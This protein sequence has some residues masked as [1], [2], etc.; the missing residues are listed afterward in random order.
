M[1]GEGQWRLR[2]LIQSIRHV[3]WKWRS[4]LQRA[5]RFYFLIHSSNKTEKPPS[6]YCLFDRETHHHDCAFDLW[7]VYERNETSDL[8]N[9][10][11]KTTWN[12]R[13]PQHLVESNSSDGYLTTFHVVLWFHKW[14]KSI[15]NKRRSKKQSSSEFRRVRFE[16]RFRRFPSFKYGKLT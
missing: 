7:Y 2:K 11:W 12:N 14:M 6:W 13:K 4:I 9:Q 5:I 3:V 1:E 16:R 8:A 15:S 10:E